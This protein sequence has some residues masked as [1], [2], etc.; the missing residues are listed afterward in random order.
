ML[1]ELLVNGG[2]EDFHVGVGFLNGLDA[3]GAA[4][5]VHHDD[6]PAAVLFQ[7]INGGNGASAGGQHG[8]DHVNH[9]V[10]DVLRQLAVVFHGLVSL[11]VAVQADVADL[12]GG[13]QLHHVVHHAET[14]AENGDDGQLLAGQHPALGGSDG[15]L[16]LHLTGGQA[17]GGLIA[18]QTGN[19][20]DQLAE[21]LNGGLLVAQNGQL[22]LDQGMIEDVYVCHDISPS[23]YRVE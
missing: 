6:V 13:N 17:A 15:G 12:G 16:H 9:P 14:R 8:I 18:H 22:M 21:F 7:K 2:Q 4:D 20:A 19:F 1:V 23:I 3:L 5:D 10:G 11:G